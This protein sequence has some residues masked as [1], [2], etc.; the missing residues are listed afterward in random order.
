MLYFY[1]IE[2][3]KNFFCATFI[4][5]DTSKIAVEKYISCDIKGDN[6]GKLQALRDFKY[7]TFII[8]SINNYPNLNDFQR[9]GMFIEKAKSMILVGYN[10]MMYDDIMI[11]YIFTNRYRFSNLSNLEINAKL[12]DFSQNIISAS[13]RSQYQARKILGIQFLGKYLSIDL[14]KL[15][16]LDNIKNRI[17]LKQVSIALKWYKVQDYVMPYPREK[18]LEYYF[19]LSADDVNKISPFERYVEEYHISDIL[20]YNIN[21]DNK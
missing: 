16:Y 17:S 7:D 2:V 6:E 3:Y 21:F 4:S 5:N 1:D 15:H 20:L 11:D 14:M 12:Y 10:N 18:E 19:N 13:F 9:L 8:S